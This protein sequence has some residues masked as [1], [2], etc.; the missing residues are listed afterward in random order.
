MPLAI[1]RPTSR[2][3]S[4]H[5]PSR[6]VLKHTRTEL[7]AARAI[8]RLG[9]ITI[10]SVGA[11][12][13]RV[14]PSLRDWSLALHFGQR[15]TLALAATGAVPLNQLVDSWSAIP[16]NRHCRLALITHSIADASRALVAFDYD[17]RVV[18]ILAS[19]EPAD[20]LITALVAEALFEGPFEVTLRTLHNR[21]GVVASKLVSHITS[22]AFR[23]CAAES[24]AAALAMH[25]ATLAAQ[26]RAEGVKSVSSVV[27]GCRV[28]H[29][30]IRM[31]SAPISAVRLAH[32]VGLADQRA[33]IS[34]IQGVTSVPVRA[35][36][37]ADRS[38]VRSADTVGI[39]ADVLPAITRS[40][41]L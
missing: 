33:L 13:V 1:I 20:Y 18:P 22:T 37:G 41:L 29:A 39:L 23:D 30:L 38:E 8:G 36:A 40:V 17:A 5:D 6:L 21:W 4:L 27:R 31:R 3:I 7:L 2:I 10:S 11:P 12:E 15:V 14:L 35:L 19:L 16:P 28:A 26:L 32:E 34:A 25:R 24:L 9:T